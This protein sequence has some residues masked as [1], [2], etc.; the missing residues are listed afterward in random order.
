MSK[1]ESEGTGVGTGFTLHSCLPPPQMP[2]KRRWKGMINSCISIQPTKTAPCV[3]LQNEQSWSL[4]CSTHHDKPWMLLLQGKLLKLLPSQL[5][6]SIVHHL[7]SIFSP[8]HLWL[9]ISPAACLALAG[10]QGKCSHCS[11]CSPWVCSFTSPDRTSL[12]RAHWGKEMQLLLSLL[13]TGSC[14]PGARVNSLALQEGLFN[15]HLNKDLN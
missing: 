10:L 12:G 2:D 8:D 4:G 3:V 11:C 9:N 5:C 14:F 1:G 13:A 6:P 15:L 7:P